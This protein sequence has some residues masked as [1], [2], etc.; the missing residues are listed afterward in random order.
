MIQLPLFFGADKKYVAHTGKM[1]V[2]PAFFS[3]SLSFHWNACRAVDGNMRNR[4]H[5]FDG[6]LFF[7]WNPGN[8]FRRVNAWPL[9][10]KKSFARNAS[11]SPWWRKLRRRLWSRCDP[12]SPSA[13]RLQRR[14]IRSTFLPPTERRVRSFHR[15]CRSHSPLICFF[16]FFCRLATSRMHWMSE[17]DCWRTGLDCPG[18]SVACL[19]FQMRHMR[20]TPPWRVHGQV[21]DA[22]LFRYAL[23]LAWCNWPCNSTG[24]DCRI[25]RKT[26]S[27]SSASS[28]TIVSALL[29]AKS[30]RY[31][32]KMN[33]TLCVINL[34]LSLWFV[35]SGGR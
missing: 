21:S 15:V 24:M 13:R 7:C 1:A 3:L 34:K 17:G 16:L 31:V 4:R 27:V 2:R 5:F 18:Q 29:R 9:R 33:N 25:A 11:T 14:P 35:D 26:T 12:A 28:V 10:G 23:L 30:F 6:F 20:G 8:R 22:L 32:W 19:V